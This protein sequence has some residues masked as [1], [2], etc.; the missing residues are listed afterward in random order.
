MLAVAEEGDLPAQFYFETRFLQLKA[1]DAF[2]GE[3]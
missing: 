2:I 3:K 1:S